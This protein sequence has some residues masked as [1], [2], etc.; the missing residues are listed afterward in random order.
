MKVQYGYMGK[1]LFVNLTEKKIDEEEITER[2]ARDFIGGYGIGARMIMERM[3]PGIDPLGPENI[4]GVGTG[5]LTL[6]GA[7]STCRFHTMGKSPLTNYWGGANS[8]GN[9]ANGLKAS[10]YD[11]VFF[12]GK[13]ESPVYLLIREGKAE[14]KDARHLWGMDTVQ[15]EEQIRKDN[16]DPNL[17]IV[18][19]GMA[20]ERLSRIAAVMNDSGRAAARSGLGAVMGSKNLKAV[21]CEGS[22]KPNLFDK[23]RIES[24]VKEMAKEI[25][26]NPSG[27]YQVLSR[28]GT[29]GAVVPHLATHD[30]PIKN[31]G[32]N[33]IE[34][35]PEEKWAKVGWEG[36]QKYTIKKYACTGCPIACGHW[37]KVDIGK[38]RVEK[39]H[40]PEYETLA[41]FGPMCLNDNMESIIYA[42]ELCNLHGF[43]TISAGAVIAFAIECYENGIL[44]K[45]E[46]DGLELTWGNS[47]AVIEVLKKMAKREGIGDLLAD[48]AKIA[49]SK[50]G[51]GAE[52]F[53][54]HVGGEMV[55]MHDPRFAPGWGATYVSDPTPARHTRGGT[56]F[57]ES[58]M[59]NPAIF[60][61]WG[62]KGLPDKLEKYD[63]TGKGKIHAIISA[64]Q[65]LVEV[66]GT[67]LFAADGLNFPFIDLMKAITG[68]DLTGD[69]LITTGQRIATLLHAFNLREGFKP[70]EFTMPPRIAG[71]PPLK[72]GALKD[73]TLDLEGL[74]RQYYE[75]MGFDPETGAIRKDRI[76]AL[77][78]NDIL[79]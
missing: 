34:D 12:E 8:G 24:L 25:K 30:T 36:L 74:K 54:M 23:A 37:M 11:L 58:G 2:L 48:G 9:F 61:P 65:Y 6:S 62:V 22:L 10:G 77:G 67:C 52:K 5:P 68:W 51:R 44:T 1:M 50:I 70:K 49:A 32:G 31:W 69:E 71:N 29:A 75:A 46:T 15:T 7:I 28:T 57:L 53:A 47:D 43:D 55:P 72:V 39:G 33:N 4:F 41:A 40:K 60:A 17:K 56:Q 21:A 14:I 27:M 79:S 18:S 26:E 73:I 13:A 45:R 19:I 63:P 3:K 64:R 20:G 59:V 38:Y 76:E 78:L 16:G 66:S 35:F 42:N